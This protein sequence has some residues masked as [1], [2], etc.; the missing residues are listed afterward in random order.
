MSKKFIPN[1]D[2]DF[3]TM[4]QGFARTVAGDP[5]RFAVSEDDA[6]ALT[7]AVERFRATFQSARG[8]IRSPA[9][10][11]KKEQAR[12]LAEKI[13]RR[14]VHVVRASDRIDHV[15]KLL[16]GLRERTA[17]AKVL[18]VPNEAPRLKFVRAIHEGNGLVPEHELSFL[19]QNYKTKPVGAVRL[20][21]F[22]DLITPDAPIPLCPGEVR[23]S[24]PFYVRSFTRSPIRFIPPMANVAMRVVYWARWADSTGNVGPFSA[25]AV[26]WIEGGW[27][28]QLDAARPGEQ[29]TT[30]IDMTDDMHAPE[31]QTTVVV[32]L[33]EAIQNNG[34]RQRTVVTS[35]EA[36]RAFGEPV[37]RD[38]RQLEGPAT[39][40]A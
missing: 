21:L 8:G 7:A 18:T 14:I 26:G 15:S 22:V 16:L 23:G 34:A 31:Q 2:L 28:A 20:E 12:V 9:A 32:A 27:H 37:Q 40:A 13:I 4:A 17:K 38:A 6:A 3:V 25:T 11:A 33:F 5:S 30:L 35:N 10:T 24:R 19:S 29:R 39:E 1:G 36:A